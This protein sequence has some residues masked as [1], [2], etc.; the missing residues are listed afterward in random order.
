MQSLHIDATD[1]CEMAC[2][3]MQSED[4][5]ID[6]RHLFRQAIRSAAQ[7]SLKTLA[8]RVKEGDVKA[9]HPQLWDAFWAV[10]ASLPP[11]KKRLFLKFVT[12]VDRLPAP[13]SEVQLPRAC[14]QRF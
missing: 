4:T 6:I 9:K 7:R 10:V 14:S 3:P 2:G 8:R 13:G 12:G 11:R 1:L 5:D